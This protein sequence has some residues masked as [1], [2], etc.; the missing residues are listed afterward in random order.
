ML[1]YLG[2]ALLA[3]L[4]GGGV[5]SAVFLFLCAVGVLSPQVVADAYERLLLGPGQ[6][7][8]PFLWYFALRGL[9]RLGKRRALYRL[10]AR[11]DWGGP[12]W[13]DPGGAVALVIEELAG[14]RPG[15][16][17]PMGV[18]FQPRLPA[19]LEDFAL[20]A[21]IGG[22]LARVEQRE[23]RAALAVRPMAGRRDCRR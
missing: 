12:R 2:R 1:K 11:E 16:D 22:Q 14:L 23:W 3:L 8:E 13:A 20:Q 15:P 4:Y 5:L 9:G 18:R 6:G 17:M 10:L 21:P 7:W 19:E